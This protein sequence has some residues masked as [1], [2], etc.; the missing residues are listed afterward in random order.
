HVVVLLG[1]GDFAERYAVDAFN[2]VRAE[3]VHVFVLAS[4]FEGD[5]RNDNTQGQGLDTDLLVSVFTLGIQE[6]VD[7]WVVCVQVNGTG[8]LTCTELVC[9]GEGIFKKLHHWDDA[10]GLVLDLLDRSTVLAQVGQRQRNAAAAL[11]KLQRGVYGAGNRLHVVFNAKQEAGDELAALSLAGVQERWS[12]RLETA[13]DDLIDQVQS[14]LFIA[15]CQVQCNHAHAVFVA[16]QVALTIEGLQGVRGVELES[17]QEG[18]KTELLAE[19]VLEQITDEVHRVLVE[20]FTLVVLVLHQVFKLLIE[21][22]EEHG[23]VVHVIQEVLAGSIAVHLK[24]NLSIWT[25]KV[26]HGVQIVV[27]QALELGWKLL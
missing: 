14:Q 5:I 4:K 3:Q 13:F 8:T 10:G 24:L 18:F 15:T 17:A 16:F 27:A 2:V 7:V 11:G 20:G 26:Q 12:C 6:A 22:M 1:D 23:V 19:G 25:V 9:V 21:I